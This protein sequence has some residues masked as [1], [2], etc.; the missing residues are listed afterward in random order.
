MNHH[1]IHHDRPARRRRFAG[2]TLLEIIVVVV[3][4]LVLLGIGAAVGPAIVGKGETALTRT[5]LKN[6]MLIHDELVLLGDPPTSAGEGG[7]Q[8]LVAKAKQYKQTQKL[9]A[10]MPESALE[11]SSGTYL[12]DGWGN[13]I[14][15]EQ[16][17]ATATR[18]ARIYF[19]SKGPN[20]NDEGVN[21]GDDIYSY[22]IRS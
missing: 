10:T 18:P 9:L 14:L 20:G 8:Q 5:V 17:P 11:G 15:L 12:L 19:K 22:E 6:A 21:K 7:N 13:R 4:I 1:A 2:F 16:V 3:I